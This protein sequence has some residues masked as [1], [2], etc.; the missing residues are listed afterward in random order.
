MP[1]TFTCPACG[2][3]LEVK[4]GLAPAITCPHC[5][6]PVIVPESLRFQPSRPLDSRP[7]P[8]DGAGEAEIFQV[9][10][11]LLQAGQ[12]IRAIQLYRIVYADDLVTAKSMVEGI[13]AGAVTQLKP[14]VVE[15]SLLARYANPQPS[16]KDPA[17]SALGAWG[18]VLLF[19]G[20]SV[21]LILLIIFGLNTLFN[22]SQAPAP[23]RLPRRRPPPFPRQASPSRRRP[24]PSPSWSSV[25]AA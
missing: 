4:S 19:F 10:V 8:A 5:H 20:G 14:A 1:E 15:R 6:T 23:G 16:G 17:P 9:M 22:L 18:G 2:A 24:P 3:P 25:L 12:K 11:D 7:M 21:V 13:E